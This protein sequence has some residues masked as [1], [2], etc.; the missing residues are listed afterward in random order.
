MVFLAKATV[1]KVLEVRFQ[2]A[3]EARVDHLN[4]IGCYLRQVIES[5]F[6]PSPK[7]LFLAV[8]ISFTSQ[9]TY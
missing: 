9:C 5:I 3:L 1:L 2:E 7:F 4:L 6:F 8:N